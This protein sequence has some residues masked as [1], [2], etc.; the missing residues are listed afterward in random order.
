MSLVRINRNPSRRELAVFGLAWLVFFG[1]LAGA[2][3]AYGSLRAAGA[4]GAAA[5]LVPA[6]G[7]LR[8]DLMRLVWL[9]MAYASY[10]IGFVISHVILLIVYYLVLTPIGLAM[11]LAGYDP[12]NRRFDPGAESYWSPRQAPEDLGRYFRQF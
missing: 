7:R 1:V 6:L 12:M 5:V 10:P 3:W 11:R 4:L 8:P 2:A 9:A